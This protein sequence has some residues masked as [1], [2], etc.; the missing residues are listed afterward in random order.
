LTDLKEECYTFKGIYIIGADSKAR[1]QQKKMQ[2]NRN[3][4]KYNLHNPIFCYGLTDL[5]LAFVV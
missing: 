1:S 5:Q 2:Q 3:G 4:G